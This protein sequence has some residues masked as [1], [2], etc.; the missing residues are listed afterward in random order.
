MTWDDQSNINSFSKLV[1][2]VSDRESQ[3]KIKEQDK[4]YLD[5]L[6][7][8]LEL[9]DDEEKIPYRIGDSFIMIS[10]EQA[11]R[12]LEKEKEGVTTDIDTLTAE[13]DGIKEEMAR[14]KVKLKSKF[15]DS[16][17]LES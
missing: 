12:R 2:R 8:E 7:N 15:G 10:L 17:N 13:V 6:E 14:L 5:D 4:E 11:Q 9:A 1:N 16:I 3:L